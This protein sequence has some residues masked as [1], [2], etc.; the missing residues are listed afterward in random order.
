M[1]HS[2]LL[3]L[4]PMLC[5]EKME[6]SCDNS[7]KVSTYFSNRPIIAVIKPQFV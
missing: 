7:I 3:V 2:Q 5:E 4:V 1:L 6:S